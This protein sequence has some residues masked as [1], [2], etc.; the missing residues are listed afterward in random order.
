MSDP[1]SIF[2]AFA[3]QVGLKYYFYDLHTT[4]KNVR[5][6]TALYVL[7]PSPY[8]GVVHSSK[9]HT[10]KRAAHSE[11]CRVFN[12]RHDLTPYNHDKV[13]TKLLALTVRVEELEKILENK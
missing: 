7:D 4:G 12:D 8:Q 1:K 10:S 11:V 13:V 6:A 5:W 9:F 3:N 2:S